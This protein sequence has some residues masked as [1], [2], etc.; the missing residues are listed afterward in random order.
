MQFLPLDVVCWN[1][2]ITYYQ[3]IAG[4]VPDDE[5]V[6]ATEIEINLYCSHA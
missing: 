1:G 2:I 6:L 5:I 4:K 3:L